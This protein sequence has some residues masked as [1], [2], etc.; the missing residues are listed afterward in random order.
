MNDVLKTVIT[1][2]CILGVLVVVHEWG[3]FIVARLCNIR[4]DEF[5]IGFGPRAIRIGME[6]D[7]EPFIN[8]RDKAK[9]L[10]SRGSSETESAISKAPLF[11]E[12]LP[13]VDETEVQ[14]QED[15]INGFYSKPLWQRSMVIFAGPLI[16][17][18]FGYFLLLMMGCING[19]PAA[20]NVVAAVRPGS[21][22]AQIHMKVNDQIVKIDNTVIVNGD[23]MVDI[24]HGSNHKVLTLTVHRGNS[25]VILK[26][27]P[28]VQKDS[29]TTEPIFGFTPG[30]RFEHVGLAA[31]IRDGNTITVT[32]L[33]ML[34]DMVKRHNI[35]DFRQH[36]RGPVG[37]AVATYQAVK[38]GFPEVYFLAAQQYSTCCPSPYWTVVIC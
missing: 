35:T 5:S 1:Y 15:D 21:V 16:S 32:L 14:K 10:L 23:Q 22:A 24:I 8:A 31:S 38:G 2:P 30:E 28:V 17:F 4:V 27:A 11:A 6:P 3:H 18:V 26:G 13:N 12:N 9:D 25:T 34:W 36:A 20:S 7:E 19:M 37:I 33:T 29:G